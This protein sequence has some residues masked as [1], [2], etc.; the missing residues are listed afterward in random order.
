MKTPQIIKVDLTLLK[1]DKDIRE[2]YIVTV[3]NIYNA[4]NLI[5]P[6]SGQ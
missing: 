2:F 5:Q 4:M 3:Q 1:I 6:L